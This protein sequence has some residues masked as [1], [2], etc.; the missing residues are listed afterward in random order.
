M[1]SPCPMLSAAR[2]LSS[3]VEE[4]AHSWGSWWCV[5]R[6]FKASTAGRELFQGRAY[7]CDQL[8]RPQPRVVGAFPSMLEAA[9]ALEWRLRLD[10][11]R[12]RE[13]E[14]QQEVRMSSFW[15]NGMPGHVLI[16]LR[17][18]RGGWDA[19]LFVGGDVEAISH[20]SYTRED[21]I[22]RVVEIFRIRR[23]IRLQKRKATPRREVKRLRQAA[24]LMRR[25]GLPDVS[26]LL[27]AK[28]TELA[29]RF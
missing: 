23:P 1:T 3:L 11:A 4:L 18:C 21:A 20:G 17:Q 26:D 29:A 24:A 2:S 13:F 25:E 16:D 19:R 7:W 14:D 6:D 5:G 28:A 27:H 22:R 10:V 15:K 12:L 8:G 9:E